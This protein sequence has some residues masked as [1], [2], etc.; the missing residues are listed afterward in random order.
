MPSRRT[1]ETHVALLR[2]INVGGRNTLPM[3]R[4]VSLFQ[5][6]GCERVRTYIQSGNVVFEA[7][8]ARA[9]LVPA[10]VMTAIAPELG[11]DVPIVTRTATEFERIVSANPFVASDTDPDFLHVGFLANSP[12]AARGAALDP[13]RSPPDEFTLHKGELYL[14]CPNGMAR[15][16]LT[17]AYFDVALQ[18]VTTVRNWRTTL[19]LLELSRA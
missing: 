12:N 7:P 6:A 3:G 13:D 16:K 11:V 14:R 8:V 15:T 19:K 1:G 18:T 5:D 17:N 10:A 9:R 4:L 2:G